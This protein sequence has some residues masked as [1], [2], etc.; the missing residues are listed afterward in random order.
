MAAYPAGS[1]RF[2]CRKTSGL[3]GG[4]GGTI[5]SLNVSDPRRRNR[6]RSEARDG[7]ETYATVRLQHFLRQLGGRGEVHSFAKHEAGV[8][9]ETGNS[10]RLAD[11]VRLTSTS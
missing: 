10:S 8:V 4:K 1:S 5:R 2:C 6:Q 3:G 7:L 11:G 9:A